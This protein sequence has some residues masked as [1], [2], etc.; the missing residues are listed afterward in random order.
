MC[1]HCQ[2]SRR[3]REV[4]LRSRSITTC[5]GPVT[6]HRTVYECVVCRA[7]YAPV[8]K[9]LDL[10]P[11]EKYTRSVGRKAVYQGA[12]SGSF[13]LA[14]ESMVEMLGFALS[15]AEIVR[16]TEA[17][18]EQFDRLQREDESDWLRPVSPQHPSPTPVISPERLVL[19]ADGTCVL[20]VNG[21]EHK[22]VYCGRAFD[23][24]SRGRKDGSQRPF[25]VESRYAASGV[26]MGDFSQRFKALAYECGMRSAKAVAFLAD[27]AVCLWKWAEEHLPRGS[28]LIQDF[29]HVCEHL[30]QLAKTLFDD[31]NWKEPFHRWKQQ[32]EE[33]GVEQVIAELKGMFEKSRGSRR[34]ALAREIGYLEK[35]KARMDYR[36]YKQEGWPIGSGS[37][38]GTCKHL[39]KQ[40]FCGTGAR[41]RRANIPKVLALR[42]SM[43]N[44]TWAEDWESAKAA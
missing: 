23:L 5:Q 30:S 20:T 10:E 22:T 17:A 4:K 13:E 6:Y 27:G 2:K 21:E 43:F 41:W 18:G 32:I 16:A 42:V 35:G 9:E 36:R 26:D 14:H 19:S 7:S 29:W 28:V 44:G 33:S 40:R 1:P 11:G 8:D 38:E 24:S 39:V 34:K 31:E 37:I 12:Q 3:F 25:I 15:R